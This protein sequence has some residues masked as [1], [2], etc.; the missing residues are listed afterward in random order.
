MKFPL[1]VAAAMLL[2]PISALAAPPSPVGTWEVNL[3]GADQGIAYVTF[4][5][6]Q[7]FTAYGVSRE[8]NGLFTLS[9][10]WSVDEKGVLTGSYTELI[11]GESVSGSIN[12]KVTSKKLSGKIAAT[13]GDFTFKGAP[14]KVTQDLVGS[15]TGIAQV[16][17][18]RIPEIYQIAATGVP[19]VFEV[20]GTGI[21]PRGGEFT[22]SGTAIAGSAG[23]IRIFAL[24]EYPGAEVSGITNVAGTV[25]VSRTKGTLKG[26]EST[27]QAIKISL[28]R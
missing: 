14:E 16:G 28:R 5:E 20:S 19:H 23:K 9:G 15:W 26:F 17:K 1:L 13:N 24:S 3:A 6:D 4:E 12:G 18:T 27:G 22:I 10:T 25:N 8:S 21:H 7:D 11:D 2:A